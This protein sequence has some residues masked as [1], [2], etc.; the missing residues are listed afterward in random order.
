MDAAVQKVNVA[1][2]GSHII[3]PC[4][5]LV[6]CYFPLSVPYLEIPMDRRFATALDFRLDEVEDIG[7]ARITFAEMLRWFD[8][9]RITKG[10]WQEIEDRW[11]ERTNVPLLVSEGSG[12]YVLAWG[13]GVEPG[14]GCWL[15]PIAKFAQTVPKFKLPE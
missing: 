6:V 15:T 4:G 2:L 13:E 10:V 11:T 5:N 7:F 12:F 3:G 1:P 14:N 9:Q 8:R